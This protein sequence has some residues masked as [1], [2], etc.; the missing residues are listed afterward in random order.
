MLQI[1]NKQQ[2]VKLSVIVPC[3]NVSAYVLRALE[4]LRCQSLEGMEVIIV[5]DGSTDGSDGI[6]SAY[7]NALE[8][9][10]IEQFI[11]QNA[12]NNEVLAKFLQEWA[13]VPRNIVK[14]I[15]ITQDNAGYGGAVNAGIEK[16]SGE[17][18]AIC[19]PDDFVA[20]DFYEVLYRIA[21]EKNCDV[22]F[23]NGYLENR[24]YFRY[25]LLSSYVPKGL[26]G[27]LS[28]EDL[29]QRFLYNGVGICLC[30]YKRAFCDKRGL[31]LNTTSKVYQDVPFVAKVFSLCSKIYSV[32]GAKY[33]YTRGRAEQS[34]ANPTRFCDII[35]ISDDLCAFIDTNK[36]QLNTQKEYING[37]LLGH[38]LGRYRLAR[39]MGAEEIANEIGVYIS[40]F[41]TT[42]ASY[43]RESH[44]NELEKF[45]FDV[46][47][48]E[49]K[50]LIASDF[51]LWS[52][53]SIREFAN[54]RSLQEIETYMTYLALSFL[55][56][57]FNANLLGKFEWELSYYM[58]MPKTQTN[59][60]IANVLWDLL[61]VLDANFL[62]NRHPKLL[63]FI[64]IL[65]KDKFANEL[66]LPVI[67][68]RDDA[69]EVLDSFARKS[70][71]AMQT[72]LMDLYDALEC[73]YSHNEAEF[74]DY[75]F[76]KSVI[77]IG[78]SPMSLGSNMGSKIDEF[79][80]VI[81]FNNFVTEGYNQDVGSKTNIWCISPA[82]Y[83]ITPKPF[84]EFDY[85]ISN[86]ISFIKTRQRQA[87][88][89]KILLSGAKFFEIKSSMLLPKS[90]LRTP[91]FG[92][93]M[94]LYLAT[95]RSKMKKLACFG[96][97]LSEQTG[98]IKHYF[99]SDGGKSPTFHSWDIERGVYDGLIQS[100]EI[101]EC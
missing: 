91:S 77:V 38:L 23:Y 8:Q 95:H 79:E 17:F 97:N 54:G 89:T 46:S 32:C 11:N 19:E 37:Y 85:V 80:V 67:R 78:N 18:F 66:T 41:L 72:P 51:N 34:V 86:D 93:L 2:K 63:A 70:A 7:L 45:G 35:A 73:I 4:S 90:N 29:E 65:I 50:P 92:L 96:F 15:Y 48:I 49:T 76:N 28:Y 22:V 84:A 59:P 101:E 58:D 69:Q 87:Q 31:R 75:I 14:F 74:L 3:Y 25:L 44:K 36:S 100:G 83:S 10:V 26:N 33:Y 20:F 16:S 81:R 82:L 6:I 68:L 1:K 64:S 98:V 99:N 56:S 24:E 27:F 21:I 13:I 62:C 61:K 30:V 42:R 12:Q 5:N 47:L 88:L 57:G 43:T 9:G 52:L 40:Q 71:I 55:N 94:L 60:Q 53:P 39:Q